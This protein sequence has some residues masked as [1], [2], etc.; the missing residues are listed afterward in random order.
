[1]MDDK[2]NDLSIECA[3]FIADH[4]NEVVAQGEIIDRFVIMDALVAYYGD[5]GDIEY[6]DVLPTN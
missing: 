1:M 4:V 3:R 5:A 6:D 2:D